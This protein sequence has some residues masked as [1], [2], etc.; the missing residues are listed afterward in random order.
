ML[1]F[2]GFAVLDLHFQLSKENVLYTV[3]AQVTEDLQRAEREERE[4]VWQ[5]LTCWTRGSC[6]LCS[7]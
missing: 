4:E 5:K 6:C 7:P 1:T 2:G 3:L